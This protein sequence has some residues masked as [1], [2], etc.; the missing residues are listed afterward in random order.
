[1]RKLI[2]R[3]AMLLMIAAAVLIL[4]GCGGSG[5]GG[6]GKDYSGISDNTI[7]GRKVY[8]HD[9]NIAFFGYKNYL[10]SAKFQEG[11]LSEFV[12]E[13]AFTGDIYALAVEG[14]DLYVSASDGIF[15]YD[16]DMFKG[17][18][19]ASPEVLLKDRLSQFNHFQIYD[20]KLFYMYGTRLCY[21]PTE[22]GTQAEL[23]PETGDFEVTSEGIFYTKAD[24][25]LHQLSL[26]FKEDT[27]LG[28]LAPACPIS[29]ADGKIYF[30]K[31]G[32]LRVFALGSEAA[33]DFATD[34]TVS[35]HCMPWAYAGNVLY[36]DEKFNDR[37]ITAD[38]ENELGT[39]Y[40][41]PDKTSGFMY[42][43]Y[44]VS[45]NNI[46]TNLRITDLETG[47]VRE[48]NVETE[49]SQYLSQLKDGQAGKTGD[50]GDA[51]GDNGGNSGNSGDNGGSGNNGG[52]STGGYDMCKGMMTQASTDGTIEYIYFNDFLMIMP[53]NDKWGWTQTSPDTVSFFHFGA[54]QEGFVGHLVS[55]KAYDLD[56]NSYEQLP[57]YHV[58]GVGR[59][60]NKRFVAIYPTDVQFNHEDANQ[61]A[62]YRDL[63]EYLEKI[64]EGAVNS[65]LQLA[66]SD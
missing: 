39:N 52:Q 53:N 2:L 10:V 17:S 37:L 63:L 33:E 59:N 44:L 48:Y 65:P 35:E 64:G 60:V 46:Y 51:S 26:D 42:G 6:S 8:I 66:D 36:Q 31:D 3:A 19:K 58:A 30:R 50:N 34:T 32:G 49:L 9:S 18:G 12:I 15:K 41:Y 1:M 16:L 54:Q 27:A 4:A 29:L 28:E 62:E 47:V 23:T 11:S 13:G 14:N 40:N 61:E 56:D 5:S 43:K 20:G 24:G 21:I 45:L 38:G 55:I 7:M 22:G 57:S 25:S